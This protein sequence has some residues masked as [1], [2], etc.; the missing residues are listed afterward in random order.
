MAATTTHHQRNGGWAGV[1]HQQPSSSSSTSGNTSKTSAS[2]QQQHQQQV[3][4]SVHLHDITMA[5]ATNQRKR[6]HPTSSSSDDDERAT[7]SSSSSTTAAHSSRQVMAAVQRLRQRIVSAGSSPDH[8]DHDVDGVSTRAYIHTDAANFTTRRPSHDSIVSEE[9][10]SYPG[11]PPMQRLTASSPPP[12]RAPPATTTTHR[13]SEPSLYEAIFGSNVAR[14]LHSRDPARATTPPP[15]TAP[16]LPQ[17]PKRQDAR[18]SPFTSPA[19]HRPGISAK[20]HHLSSLPQLGSPERA[21]RG[22]PPAGI[23]PHNSPS[24]EAMER[25]E[26]MAFSHPRQA[27]VVYSPGGRGPRTPSTPKKR[28]RID[29]DSLPPP[30]RLAQGQES[31]YHEGREET[32]RVAGVLA[33]LADERNRLTPSSARGSRPPT[34]PTQ[35]QR[36]PITPTRH[37]DSPGG[38]FADPSSITPRRARVNT[39]NANSSTSGP[40]APPVT[41]HTEGDALAANVLL[42]FAS[43]PQPQQGHQS[44]A[45]GHGHPG[46]PSLL[47]S[48]ERRKSTAPTW[49]RNVGGGGGGGG[50]G[51]LFEA[52]HSGVLQPAAKISPP[53]YSYG[54]HSRSHTGPSAS[55]SRPRLPTVDESSTSP[56]QQ[57]QPRTPSPT[58]SSHSV[59]S[60]PRTP[61]TT[62]NC[63]AYSEF[64]NVS[65][66]PQ[67]R[68]RG[69][70]A[71]GARFVSFADGD[72]WDDGAGQEVVLTPGAFE[73]AGSPVIRRYRGLS[74]DPA[75]ASPT[76]SSGQR[77]RKRSNVNGGRGLGFDFAP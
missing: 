56:A 19:H 24:R 77:Q 70:S 10:A 74:F 40:G 26:E 21:R 5:V 65:P 76:L 8:D 11:S 9:M 59:L 36:L 57:E 3:L 17:T 42:G 51:T 64:V 27:F 63:F 61:H 50:G 45:T 20:L 14:R 55:S 13:G 29:V 32:D 46:T 69:P 31:R 47:D 73:Q 6:Q 25:E 28:R 30:P 1:V 39:N 75:T 34:T 37:Q 54:G 18:G 71:S 2:V 44:Q 72:G 53:T 49:G 60:T 23:D 48:L 15:S 68:S 62:S 7:P 35:P 4:T 38:T 58:P 41:P 33:A 67:P 16:T 22:G 12:P 43:S 52:C 66:S